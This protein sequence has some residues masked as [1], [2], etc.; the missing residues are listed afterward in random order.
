M[1]INHLLISMGI[2]LSLINFIPSV[3]A[4]GGGCAHFNNPVPYN[5][6]TDV[7][8][9][10]KGVQ[11]CINI[12]IDQGCSANISL[13]WY[14]WTESLEAGHFWFHESH[15]YTYYNTSNITTS[16]QICAYNIN[17]T[18]A[19]E[20]WWTEYMDWRVV[21][22]FTC[23]GPTYYNETCQFYYQ[24][25]DCPIFKYI[26][27]AY[28][29][30]ICPC[31]D[32]FCFGVNNT[33]G[34]PMNITIYGNTADKD[35]FYVLN[36]YINT[37]NGTYC[38]CMDDFFPSAHAI[39]WSESNVTALTTDT[40]YNFSFDNFH[41]VNMEGTGSAV[42]IPFDGHYFLEYW[43]VSKNDEAAPKGDV[44]ALRMTNN[45][46]EI[47]ASYR[48]VDFI[49]QDEE[50]YISSRCH[51]EFDA[52]D[53]INFQYIVND[54]SCQIVME[55]DYTTND[56]NAFASIESEE[57]SYPFLYN[58]TYKWYINVTDTIT[59]ESNNSDIF[60]FRT[61]SNES[62]C[63]CGNITEAFDTHDKVRDDA[64]IIGLAVLFGGIVFIFV[65][66]K[67]P[68]KPTHENILNDLRGN[69]R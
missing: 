45:G 35:Y 34:N 51:D 42:I 14:N 52:G 5:G 20:K 33:N 16:Q 2:I 18:C 1:K 64:W 67:E 54:L 9:G 55:G 43:L 65:K 37:S 68:R 27:P 59:G 4:I 36:K 44:I 58:T 7:S 21:G 13:Q 32:C 29:S 6:Q 28:N 56:T 3:E 19:T 38:F 60:Y 46:H 11:T 63:F 26:S 23:T 17:V 31:C 57:H 50:K 39:G 48:Q 25:A 15:W 40:W 66:R 22:N 69:I 61:A 12:T 24:T 10:V 47:N 62:D 8:I 53:I 30:T 49:N 41:A